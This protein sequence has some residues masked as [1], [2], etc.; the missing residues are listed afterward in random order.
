MNIPINAEIVIMIVTL[1][2]TIYKIAQLEAK[3]YKYVDDLA[4][5]IA[6]RQSVTEKD[7]AV[8]FSV[9]E[10]RKETVDY[11]I[12]SLNQK[13]DHKFNRLHGWIK[14]L[15]EFLKDHGYLNK[16]K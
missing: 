6:E 7:L 12:N 14:D 8:H 15:Q 3:I 5:N 11:Q 9:Y 10:E 16:E 4:K 13:I 2:A 1:T